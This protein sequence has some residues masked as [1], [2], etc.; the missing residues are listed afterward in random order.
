MESTVPTSCDISRRQPAG[1]CRSDPV[2]SWTWVQW[3]P[4]SSRDREFLMR[5]KFRPQQA[6]D[7]NAAV[8][9]AAVARS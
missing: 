6:W 4:V 5:F 3:P 7:D 9:D 1:P 8:A 2:G